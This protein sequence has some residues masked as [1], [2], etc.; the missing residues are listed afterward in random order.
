MRVEKCFFCGSPCY[1]GKGITFVR[2]DCKI[3]KFC[4]SK[5]HK[6]FKKKKNPRKA[7]WTKAF[8]KGAGKELAIDPSFEFE[9]RRN[10]PVKYDREL[11][12]KTV[13][14][15]KRVEEIKTRRQAQFILDRQKKARAIE[16]KKDV[17]E[18]QRDIAL[19]KSP[20]IGMKRAA[21]DM[22]VDEEDDLEDEEVDTTLADTTETL[23]LDT[24]INLK[25][26]GGKTKSAAK[27]KKRVKI[28]EEAESDQEMEAN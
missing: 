23:E 20:A 24:S 11:W 21:K 4:R 10:I 1:P 27:A 19:I 7:K 8:R 18:V 5:C 2:N 28:I 22:D 13:G 6:N 17:K 26:K 15:M 25:T 9:K 12:Q 14:A 3:F 16:R